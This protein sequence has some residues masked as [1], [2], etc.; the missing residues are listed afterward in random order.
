MLTF[1]NQAKVLLYIKE[2]EANLPVF[3][4]LHPSL[5]CNHA[6][7]WCRYGKSKDKLT[8]EQMMEPIIKNPTIKGVR[9]TGGGEPLTNHDAVIR[10]IE[11]CHVLGISTSIET[12]GGL[13]N[14]ESIEVIAK[15]CRY[16]RISLD[17]AT[18]QTHER[19]HGSKDFSK[20]LDNL[21]RLKQAGIKELGLSFLVVPEN[22]RELLDLRDL[23]LPVDYIHFKPIIQGIDNRTRNL[24][25]LFCEHWERHNSTPPIRWDRLEQDDASN[26]N[27]PCRIT[28]LIRLLGGDGVEYVCC[29]HAYKPE[30][31]VDKWNGSTRQCVS[32][33][34]N[35]YNEIL[36]QY[37]KN[38]ISREF[39]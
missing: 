3:L 15:Y 20:I 23:R 6:C 30:F 26:I 12:N 4:E 24:A 5:S 25:M 9:I 1:Y 27:T 31:A 7:V 13:L 38:Q 36:E 18:P 33:R 35:G 2:I 22:V 32:C 39:L 17:A 10:F 11:E 37:Y 19:L 34:Y 8:Y 29:E 21:N 14:S 28:R 16:C